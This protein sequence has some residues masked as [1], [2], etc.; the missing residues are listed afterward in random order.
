MKEK[1]NFEFKGTNILSSL[2]CVILF[3]GVKGCGLL[4]EGNVAENIAV[5]NKD[6]LHYLKGR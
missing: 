3:K 6:L 2:Y 5:N 1:G 4:T